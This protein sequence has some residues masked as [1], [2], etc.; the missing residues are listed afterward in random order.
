M[1]GSMALVA[2]HNIVILVRV[3]VQTHAAHR[4]STILYERGQ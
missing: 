4:N 2:E 1:D 3:V